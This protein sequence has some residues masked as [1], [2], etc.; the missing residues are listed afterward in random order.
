MYERRAVKIHILMDLRP[1]TLA[2]SHP[3]E[4]LKPF[5][6]PDELPAAVDAQVYIWIAP[7]KWLKPD[8]WDYETFVNEKLRYW[9]GKDYDSSRYEDEYESPKNEVEAEER[10]LEGEGAGEL[11]VIAQRKSRRPSQGFKNSN[12]GY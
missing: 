12:S 3:T 9:V 1:I 4:L 6:L 11:D 2:K 10:A 8:L 5:P 7:L